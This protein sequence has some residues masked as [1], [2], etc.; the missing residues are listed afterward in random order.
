MLHPSPRLR[1][2]MPLRPANIDAVDGTPLRQMTS[3]RYHLFQ[4]DDLKRENDTRGATI[5]SFVSRSR[6]SPRTKRLRSDL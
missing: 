6:V 5:I 3:S 2:T 4:N 1:R